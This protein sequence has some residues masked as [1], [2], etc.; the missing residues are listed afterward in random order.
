MNCPQFQCS[1]NRRSKYSKI[2]NS[3]KNT[4][5][6]WIVYFLHESSGNS[7]WFNRFCNWSFKPILVKNQ[8]FIIV[9]LGVVSY[10]RSS[11]AEHLNWFKCCQ[12]IWDLTVKVFS[13]PLV[14]GPVWWDFVWV[15]AQKNYNAFT[16]LET[17]HFSLFPRNLSLC[18][19]LYW[20]ILIL[21]VQ[22]VDI[23]PYI[24]AGEKG[25][26]T[27]FLL[28]LLLTWCAVLETGCFSWKQLTPFWS[29]LGYC[30]ILICSH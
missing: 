2:Y 6:F 5:G 12:L 8:V 11:P 10:S 27:V 30:S 17:P 7:C 25:R 1:A 14:L 29:H 15:L 28:V 16:E 22:I 20:F 26:K 9:L 24:R 4:T 23:T 21:G 3:Q 13:C 19:I 18:R